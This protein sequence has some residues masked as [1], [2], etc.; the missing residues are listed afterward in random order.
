LIGQRLRS[1]EA[2]SAGGGGSDVSVVQ[3][4]STPTV[5][6]S[7]RPKRLLIVGLVVGLLL[8]AALG[9]LRAR[10]D[11][12]IRDATEFEELFPVPLVGAIPSSGKLRERGRALP[13]PPVLEAFVSARTS[14]RYLHVGGDLRTL[15]LTS[16]GSGEGK[17]TS[18]WY[19]AVA[20]AIADS[21]VLVIEADLRQPD[22]ARRLSMHP[23]AGLTEVLAG[24]R[25]PREVVVPVP[26]GDSGNVLAGSVDVIF[27][28]ALP[29]SPIP[30]LERGRLL[31]LLNAV[32][33]RYDMVL[34]DTPPTVVGDALVIAGQADAVLV[35]A[36]RGTP[37]R[38]AFLRAREQLEGTGTPVVGILVNGIG[39]AG[40][41]YGYSSAGLDYAPAP[42]AQTTRQG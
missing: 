13:P 26:F 27:A 22:M 23:E 10:F 40:G 33:G 32:R 5:A 12:R 19:L 36:R 7:P 37:T 24:L 1:V 14:L 2:I 3:T 6:S 9:L 21:R 29:P 18:T 16:T 31:D 25:S 4:A 15:V 34:I 38:R 35:V 28:G 8:G 42:A 17:T 41:T 20:A 30:L 39:G 11:D